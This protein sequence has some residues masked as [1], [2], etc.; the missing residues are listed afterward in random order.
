MLLGFFF[1]AT[2]YEL[3]PELLLSYCDADPAFFDVVV[4]TLRSP[5]G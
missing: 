3:G 1:R 4:A 2:T 5:K